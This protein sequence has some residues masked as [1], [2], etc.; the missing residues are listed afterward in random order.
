MY[1][2]E[3]TDDYDR[4]INEVVDEICRRNGP[5]SATRF[6]DLIDELG[7]RLR[8][9]PRLYRVWQ[10]RRK[11]KK[12]YRITHVWKYIILYRVDEAAENVTLCHIIH[13]A[14]DFERLV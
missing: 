9:S 4:Q 6:L 14:R 8:S 2:L 11:L 1:R 12:T 3:Q 13:G 10:P 5:A 7:E